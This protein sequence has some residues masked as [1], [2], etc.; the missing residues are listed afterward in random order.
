MN[1]L[2]ERDRDALVERARRTSKPATS[3]AMIGALALATGAVPLDVPEAPPK[4][5]EQGD[6]EAMCR[7]ADKRER[8]ARK[9]ARLVRNASVR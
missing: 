6:L 4:V 1:S 8:K 5:M 9:R 3:L 7:A 2:D